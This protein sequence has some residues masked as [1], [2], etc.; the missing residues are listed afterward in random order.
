MQ[1]TEWR[2]R[3]VMP[4]MQ[5]SRAMQRSVTSANDRAAVCLCRPPSAD[6]TCAST[7][8]LTSIYYWFYLYSL[9]GI[10]I[11]YFCKFL[12]VDLGIPCSVEEENLTLILRT[13]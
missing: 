3:R 5:P 7:F 10:G 6:A 2:A 1:R 11:Q 8:K 4:G 9:S 13:L 12:S